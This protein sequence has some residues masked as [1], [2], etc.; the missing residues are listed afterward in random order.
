MDV[1]IASAVRTPIGGFMGA[2]APVPATELGALV[3]AEA[4]RRA[5][6]PPGRVDEVLMGN[7]LSAGLGQNPARQA[8]LRAG[9]PETVPATTVNMVCGSGLRAVALAAQAIRAGDAEVVVAGGMENMS[10]AP[11]LLPALRAGQRMGDATVVDAMVHDGLWCAMCDVHMGITAENIAAEDGITRE[12]QDAFAL[13]SQQRASR[14]IADGVFA[15]EILPVTVPARRGPAVVVDRDENPR[16][17]TTLEALGRLRPAFDP[18]GTVTA[19]SSSG[20]NDG[21][22]ATVVMSADA[23][24]EAGAPVLGII[25][26]YAS[27]GVA[28]RVMGLGPVDA[29]RTA[30]TRA[31][32]TLADLDLIELNEAFAAQSLAVCRRL[33]LDPERTNVHGGAIALGH[34]IG[35]SGARVLT[36][37]LHSMGREQARLGLASLCIG[38]GQGIAMVVERP[39]STA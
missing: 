33:G 17:D 31:G 5:G 15:G 27:V 19:G 20:I 13:R 1:V 38:G 9:V 23:A 32:V 37:L 2:L 11:H 10:A 12:D 21:A 24:R 26:G 8:A 4:L 7:V 25:R 6:T 29:V 39:A 22:A 18:A 34:P 35:A 36:T 16:P 3:V 30:M 14:A 28:P